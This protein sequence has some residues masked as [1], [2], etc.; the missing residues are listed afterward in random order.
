MQ[1]PPPLGLPKRVPALAFAALLLS[2]TLA[3]SPAFAKLETIP[4]PEAPYALSGINTGLFRRHAMLTLGAHQL[5]AYIGH[6]GRVV[7]V[8]L[9]TKGHRIER[10]LSLDNPMPREMLGDGHQ[11]ISMGYSA[12]GFLHLLWGCHDTEHPA[13]LKLSW[14]QLAEVSRDF[15]SGLQVKRLSYPQFFGTPD[16]L[17]MSFRRDDGP[18][19]YN[20]C[21]HWLVRYDPARGW[22][23]VHAPLVRFPP[24]PQLAYLNTMGENKDTLAIAYMLRRYDLM[25]T[26]DPQMHVKND[27]LRV[28]WSPDLGRTWNGLDGRSI[29]LPI[30][31]NARAPDVAIG[32]DENLIN[33]GGGWLGAD[34]WYHIA[35]FR[36][37]QHSV[38][39]IYLTS[40]QLTTGRQTTTCLTQRSV[41]FNLLG[42][43]TQ[44]WPISRPAVFQLGGTLV[45][46]YREEDRLM[47]TWLPRRKSAWQTGRLYTGDLGN[48]EPIVDYSALKEGRLILY[49]QRVQQGRDDR[50]AAASSS[51]AQAW[52]LALREADLRSLPS[53]GTPSYPAS[54]QGK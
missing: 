15:P 14:P 43:G 5:V 39:Q 44:V 2:L 26:S 10:T 36:N 8:Q 25:D 48:Y 40:F 37:D 31:A 46:V 33:Q 42:R 38:P 53:G 30:Q 4:L 45:V 51:P 3:V 47:V 11:G 20:P 50:P 16:Q 17:L 9:S 7:L 22:V 34:G 41:R 54:S 12:D 27:S 19:D 13:Y 29:P 49:I 6:D 35:Y 18:A 21:D 32:R 1:T 52:L 23:S 28:A 24:A